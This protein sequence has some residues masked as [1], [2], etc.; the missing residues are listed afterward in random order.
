MQGDHQVGMTTSGTHCPYLGIPVAMAMVD[1]DIPSEG[2]QV[3]VIVRGRR[4]AAE[5][6]KLPFYRRQRRKGCGAK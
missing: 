3:E 1:Q 6:V 4:I 5:T 2:G